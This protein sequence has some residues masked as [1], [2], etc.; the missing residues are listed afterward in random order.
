MLRSGVARTKASPVLLHHRRRQVG[1]QEALHR[2]RAGAGAAAAVRG[3]ERLVHVHVDDVESH[4]AEA[5]PAQEGVEVGA[6]AVEEGAPAMEHLGDLPDVRAEEAEGVGQG[7]HHRCHAL[8]QGGGEGGHVR[9][10]LGVRGDGH[11]LEAGHGG[12]GR[13]R[14]VGGIG[15]Q[16]AGAP[17][18]A[19]VGQIGLDDE[20]ARELALGAG[21]GRQAHGVEAGDLR[22]A[23]LEVVHQGQ[24]A[25]GRLDR[26]QRVGLGEAGQA[27]EVFVHLRVVLHGAAAQGIE[28]GVDAVVEAAEGHEVADQVH[29]AQLGQVEVATQ[30]VG[31]R[32]GRLRHV[33][34][35][36]R[37][38]A[39]ARLRQVEGQAV[40]DAHGS[41]TWRTGSGGGGALRF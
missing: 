31:R 41:V 5:G 20:H 12:R 9:V 1:R 39:P 28:A 2:D 34:R 6:V 25:L 35:R 33:E 18:L 13:V 10:A 7:E 32:Q 11:D 29:L 38:G 3:A 30:D 14:A 37:A 24:R 8:V 27:G 26:L 19:V 23:A 4:V 16:D 36:Q 15:H 22:Q 17:L 40:T 21:G